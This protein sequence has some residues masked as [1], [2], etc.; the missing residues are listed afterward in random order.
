M[1]NYYLGLLAMPKVSAAALASAEGRIL[2]HIS[3]PPLTFRADQRI[4]EGLRMTIRHLA[5]QVGLS[6]EALTTGL[7]GTC[8]AMGGVNHESDRVVLEQILRQIGIRADHPLVVCNNCNAHLAAS[9][10]NY[11]GVVRAG[12]GAMI[13]LLGHGVSDPIVVDGWGPLIGDDG[14]GYDL[15][16]RALRA[17]ASG[18]D[19]RMPPSDSLRRRVLSHL[20]LDPEVRPAEDLIHWARSIME[21]I[22]WVHEVSDLAIPL[23][24][25]AE[26]DKDPL[27]QKL[28]D[29]GVAR[30]IRSFRTAA[31]A[32][33]AH[34][35]RFQPEPAPLLLH[36]GLFRH[37]KRYLSRFVD[38]L[39]ASDATCLQWQIVEPLAPTVVGTLVLA[40]SGQD[41]VDSVLPI[42][43]TLL[44]SAKAQGWTPAA[45]SAAKWYRD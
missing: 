16:R 25:A 23:I 29:E 43:R 2:G 19:G 35:E 24:R 4:P 44:D 9:L 31:R 15:G 30:V 39:A 34:R 7:R 26:F 42:H 37:S 14:S 32:A 12:T 38:E 36:G 41:R 11:G 27:A 40:V 45:A 33:E 20:G 1:E 21:D 18:E 5:G 3:A 8:I 28:I 6:Y 17:V 10:L 13:F 22:R